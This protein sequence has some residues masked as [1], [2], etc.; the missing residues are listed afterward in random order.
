MKARKKIRKKEMEGIEYEEKRRQ[1]IEDKR[2]EKRKGK[3]ERAKGVSTRP[4]FEV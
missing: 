2:T 3:R 4:A 1:K